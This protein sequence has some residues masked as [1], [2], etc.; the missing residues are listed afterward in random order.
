MRSLRFGLA[1][2]C[3][4]SCLNAQS[5]P[6]LSPGAAYD[7]AMRPF[8]ATRHSIA[9]W[10]DIEIDALKVTIARAAAACH[11]RDVKS[12]HGA[13]LIDYAKLCALG[14][15]WPMVVDATDR[16]IKADT[17]DKPML[18]QAYVAKVDAELHLKDEAPALA[19]ALQMLKAVPYDPLVAQAVDETV[20][21]MELM[22]TADALTLEAA[23]RPI[24]MR[25]LTEAAA[26]P[27][28][29]PASGATAKPTQSLHELYAEGLI[30]A[31]IQQLA[32]KPEEA[33]KT[34]AEFSA[35]LPAKLAPDELIPIAAAR[36]RY[37]FLG[38]PL[39]EI[40]MRESLS[41]PNRLPELPAQHAV[42]A[43]LLF[44]DWCSQ[45]IRIGKD[46]PQTV[47]QVEGNEAYLFGLMAQTLPPA[48]KVTVGSGEP[49]PRPGPRELLAETPTVVVPPG[50]LTQFAAEDFPLLIMTDSHG[51]VRLLQSVSDDVLQPGGTLDTA[52]SRVGKTWP[53][54]PPKPAAAPP[55]SPAQ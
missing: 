13:E 40:E 54:N 3:L 55:A 31:S 29:K 14:Q 49:Q 27:G 46:F 23:R 53:L 47:F 18:P 5:A 44:P 9:N 15:A 7:D 39:P 19:D 42:T 10:S 26:A 11:E 1:L 21:Y 28:N 51:V 41:L 6:Q 38:K 22:Y 36:K 43:L 34:V 17:P 48:T 24:L 45:C 35:A 20:D 2:F 30:Y 12:F 4:S 16:Y 25:L 52:V 8:D 33:A 50:V 37:S 32:N